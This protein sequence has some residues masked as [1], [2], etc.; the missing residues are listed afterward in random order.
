MRRHL[1]APELFI[2]QPI[3]DHPEYVIAE[4]LDSGC[5]G[6]VFVARSD[7]L[8]REIACKVIPWARRQESDP[9]A[10]RQVIHLRA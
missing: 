8:R 7:T 3:P 4:K 1:P 9:F 5:N 6:H 10:D 2:G